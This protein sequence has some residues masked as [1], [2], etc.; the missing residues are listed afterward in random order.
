MRAA[1]YNNPV[2]CGVNC[3]G[4]RRVGVVSA[5][6][7]NKSSSICGRRVPVGLVGVLVTKTGP[8]NVSKQVRSQRVSGRLCKREREEGQ[9]IYT[10]PLC[11]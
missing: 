1:L 4:R 11:T 9:S 7:L 3:R 2:T 6:E 8:S 5:V 10:L